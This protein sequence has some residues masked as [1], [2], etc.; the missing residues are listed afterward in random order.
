MILEGDSMTYQP[1]P[2]DTAAVV[3]GPEVEELVERLAESIHDNWALRRMSEGW[4][5]GPTRDDTKKLH[6]DL[7]P[8]GDLAES[9]KE[10]DRTTVRETVKGILALGFEIRPKN[11]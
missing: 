3:L 11:A 5:Y 7:V 10:Y 9:E 8:Y 6:P 4:S 1:E 2:I